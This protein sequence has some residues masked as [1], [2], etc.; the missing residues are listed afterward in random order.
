MQEQRTALAAA[1]DARP[2]L[3]LV[4]GRLEDFSTKVR[5]NLDL[6]DW[7]AKRDVIRLMSAAARWMMGRS[8]LD[9]ASCR[10]QGAQAGIAGLNPDT[11]D[12]PS[13]STPSAQRP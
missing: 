12:R 13:I 6:L 7:T 11:P 3:T 5:E 9:F 8:R 2:D 4:T 1:V 10:P